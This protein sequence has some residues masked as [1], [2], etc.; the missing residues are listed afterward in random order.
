MGAMREAGGAGRL[1]STDMKIDWLVRT[2]KEM[3]DEVACK[4]EIK[5]MIREIEVNWMKLNKS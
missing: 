5:S 1:S 4:K 2:V 3:K